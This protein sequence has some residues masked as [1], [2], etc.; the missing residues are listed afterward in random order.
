MT[1]EHI[2][3]FIALSAVFLLALLLAL[4]VLSLALCATI[5]L[6]RNEVSALNR[7]PTLPRRLR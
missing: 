2:F 6:V 1:P 3:W 7:P 5:R 4:A